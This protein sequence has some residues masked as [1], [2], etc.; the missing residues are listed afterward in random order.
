[1]RLED[2]EAARSDGRP[3]RRKQPPVLKERVDHDVVVRSR[4]PPPVEI[5]RGPADAAQAQA[6]CPARGFPQRRWRDIDRVDLIAGSGEE[7]RVAAES[8]RNVECSPRPRARGGRHRFEQPAPEQFRGRAVVRPLTGPVA[9]FPSCAIGLHGFM[10]NVRIGQRKRG[11]VRPRLR[12][13]VWTFG[14]KTCYIGSSSSS[15][16]LSASLSSVPHIGCAGAGLIGDGAIGG[17]PGVI[18]PSVVCS[19][20]AAAARVRLGAARFARAPLRFWVPARLAPARPRVA[21]V[22]RVAAVRRFRV[23]RA[24]DRP[25]AARARPRRDPVVARPLRDDALARFFRRVLL[26]ILEPPLSAWT[27]SPGTVV[28]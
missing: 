5:D 27:L 3:Q 16:S 26:A 17:S 2:E 1:M 23:E 4:R 13:S 20:G 19:G 24:D 10:I 14:A 21:P 28:C 11:R 7:Q 12:R 18:V 15:F 8:C 9:G 6:P 22:R 25:F